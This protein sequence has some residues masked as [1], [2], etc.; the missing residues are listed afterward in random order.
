[1]VPDSPELP[2]Q[3]S[4]LPPL[5]SR[6]SATEMMDFIR[7]PF[8]DCQLGQWQPAGGLQVTQ[9]KH[10]PMMLITLEYITHTL[11]TWKNGKSK[12]FSN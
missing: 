10:L 4:A 12:E 6:L 1:M 5:K 2:A 3:L 11:T 7:G 9:A 8:V